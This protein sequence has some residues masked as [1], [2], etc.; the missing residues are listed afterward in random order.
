MLRQDGQVGLLKGDYKIRVEYAISPVRHAL[1]SV[2][3]ALHKPLHKDLNAMVDKGIIAQ[4]TES[5]PWVSSLVVVTLK[6]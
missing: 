1:R 4:V 5:T 3:V 6:G 2:S